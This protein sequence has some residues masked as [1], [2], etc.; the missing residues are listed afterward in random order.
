MKFYAYIFLLFSCSSSFRVAQNTPSMTAEKLLGNPDF[1]AIC[2]GGY[3]QNSRAIEPTLAQI[4]EDLKLLQALNFKFIRMYNVHLK[5]TENVLQAIR[6]LRQE[7]P[8]FEMYL[9]LGAWIDCKNAWTDLPPIHHEESERNELEINEAVRLA[10]TYPDIVKVI[11]VGNEAMVK[12]ATAYYV[13][14]HIILKWVSYLQDLK[15]KNQLPKNLWITSSD[16]FAS[17]GGG[18]PSYHTSD[19][20]KLYEAVDYVSMH[21][22]PMHDTHYNP[23]FWEIE[24]EE[25]EMN[26]EQQIF[27][28]MTRA[29]E[30]AK[31]QYEGVRKYMK[32]LGIN[33]PIHI[34]E[35]GW[36]TQCNELYGNAGSGATDELKASHYYDLMKKWTDSQAIS[37]FYFEAFDE[38]WKDAQNPGGSENHFGLFTVDGK[39][40]FIVWKK[41]DE[42]VLDG[43]TRDGNPI[44]KTYDGRVD[45]LWEDVH[46]LHKVTE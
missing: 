30:Y 24:S 39:A 21:T 2:Y 34:G 40:K 23:V 7:D 25:S 19:L 22:Y 44:R 33:K 32:S 9:M 12:W 31:N 1:P 41:I 20:V 10:N 16:N 3:R 45:L 6:V 35:T 17:W 15:A 42:G 46:Y 29:V 18:D 13:E 4:K 14:P 27:S 8:S 38:T 11:S 28:R 5:E 43:L 36:A 37:M 26:K